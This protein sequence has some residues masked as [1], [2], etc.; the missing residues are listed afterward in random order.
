M[1]PNNHIFISPQDSSNSNITLVST[2]IIKENGAKVTCLDK[3]IYTFYENSILSLARK[4]N[5]AKIN[6]L[7][8]ITKLKTTNTIYVD[9]K[10]ISDSI[11]F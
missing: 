2:K 6:T 9:T 4:V 5:Q 11:R 1:I 3:T 10:L 8:G 7:L